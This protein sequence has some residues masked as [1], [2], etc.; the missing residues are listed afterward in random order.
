MKI[1]NNKIVIMNCVIS[2]HIE[3]E[4]YKIN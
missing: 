1:V 2:S 4:I 3:I